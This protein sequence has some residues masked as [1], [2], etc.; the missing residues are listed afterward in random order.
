MWNIAKFE[1]RRKWSEETWLPKK[2][3]R[4]S[5]SLFSKVSSRQTDGKMTIF[6]F[7][8]KTIFSFFELERKRVECNAES[9]NQECYIESECTESSSPG[10]GIFLK[11]SDEE[12]PRKK[13]FRAFQNLN[14]KQIEKII[15]SHSYFENQLDGWEKKNSTLLFFKEC[16]LD[17]GFVDN[18][19]ERKICLWLLQL[20]KWKFLPKF[21]RLFR[22]GR[23]YS[24]SDH[25]RWV[26]GQ[27]QCRHLELRIK[28][29]WEQNN[30]RLTISSL[31]E[32]LNL[33]GLFPIPH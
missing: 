10:Y 19:N 33:L 32:T 22:E 27:C 30:S 20:W 4:I 3:R 5:L 11:F 2:Y 7:F 6:S 17:F 13:Y 25:F 21:V 14:E 23:P 28:W 1:T 24:I 9:Q 8:D 26:R 31:F 29:Q 16:I 12:I 18:V 15:S